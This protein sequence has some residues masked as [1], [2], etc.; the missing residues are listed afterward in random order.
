VVCRLGGIEADAQLNRVGHLVDH[1]EATLD[2]TGLADGVYDLM[3]AINDGSQT[4]CHTRPLIVRSGHHKPLAKGGTGAQ[5]ARLKFRVAGALSDESEVRFNGQPLARGS[6]PVEPPQQW[7]FD[8]PSDRLRRLNHI[9]ILPGARDNL[10]VSRLQI[11]RG[12]RSYGD[13][14]FS[15]AMKRN[16][17]K[18]GAS[19]GAIDYY[20]DLTYDGLRGTP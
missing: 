12:G 7:S 5:P 8:L 20:I 17:A 2:V 13:V 14:R 10:E 9:T 15:P 1:F 18:P 11:D 19:N 16:S 4:C 6:A 3:I